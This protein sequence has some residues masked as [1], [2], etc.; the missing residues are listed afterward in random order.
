MKAVEC[1]VPPQA[2]ERLVALVEAMLL[3][4]DF[5]GSDKKHQLHKVAVVNCQLLTGL[6]CIGK[7]WLGWRANT[8]FWYGIM[9]ASN[10]FCRLNLFKDLKGA[11]ERSMPSRQP[12][13]K[14]VYEP[15]YIRGDLKASVGKPMEAIDKTMDA[16]STNPTT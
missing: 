7:L 11:L 5:F 9:I 1:F 4:S 12:H 6:E 10:S 2:V 3:C 13:L 14:D 16:S 15:T 8:V